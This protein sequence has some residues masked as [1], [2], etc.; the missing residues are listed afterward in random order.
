MKAPRESRRGKKEENTVGKMNET[1][2]GGY[3]DEGKDPA[4]LTAAARRL[5]GASRCGGALLP[6]VL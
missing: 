1:V 3:R 2:E 6:Y 5:A 4:I